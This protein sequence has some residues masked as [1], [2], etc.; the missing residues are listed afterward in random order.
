MSLLHDVSKWFG[1]RSAAK[2]GIYSNWL[3]YLDS[4]QKTDV[5][6][7]PAFLGHRFNI[8]FLL[9]ARVFHVRLLL[10]DFCKEYGAGN[11]NLTGLITRLQNP[12]NV[13]ALLVIC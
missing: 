13:S 1:E 8:L 11:A 12:F 3:A 6:S 5:P 7:L 2:H 4:N 10:V 9:A